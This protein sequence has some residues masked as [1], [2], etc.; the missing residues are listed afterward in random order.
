MTGAARPVVHMCQLDRDPHTGDAPIAHALQ[1]L[2]ALVN[3]PAVPWSLQ[4]RMMAAEAHN[5]AAA[6]L[7]SEVFVAAEGGALVPKVLD[8]SQSGTRH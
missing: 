5:R 2:A 6:R 3:D 4:A 1:W 7:H 8:M